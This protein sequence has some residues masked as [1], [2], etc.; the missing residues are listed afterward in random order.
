MVP[1]ERRAGM[2][3]TRWNL[4]ANTM[5]TDVPRT[6]AAQAYR[7]YLGLDIAKMEGLEPVGGE[8][9]DYDDK[10]VDQEVCAAC[11]S[12]LDP[13]TYPFS[14]YNGFGI[15][16]LFEEIA[17]YVPDRMAERGLAAVPENGILFGQPVANLVEWAEVAADSDAFA[18]A[19]VLDYWRLAH[20]QAPTEDEQ[21]QLAELTSSFAG[22]HDYRVERMLHDLIDTEAYYAP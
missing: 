19:T 21:D 4:V 18:R 1:A 2:L 10:G 9:I 16:G 20:G 7:A 14:R 5:F 15:D 12:T 13:L 17:T 22:E 3:T 6:T 8:P 11:H